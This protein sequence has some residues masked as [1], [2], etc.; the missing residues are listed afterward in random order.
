MY[1]K[2]MYTAGKTQFCIILDTIIGYCK[3]S[4]NFALAS[5]SFS[6]IYTKS[7]MFKILSDTQTETEKNS[8]STNF[9]FLTVYRIEKF[10]AHSCYTLELN[11]KK[12][13][14]MI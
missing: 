8:F 9:Q 3:S 5:W 12:V 11:Y 4:K 14:N 2:H 13:V 6:F 7:V 10:H 1:K